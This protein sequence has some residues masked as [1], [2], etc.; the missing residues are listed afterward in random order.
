MELDQNHIIISKLRTSRSHYLVF[1][2][3]SREEKEYKNPTLN[4]SI[5]IDSEHDSKKSLYKVAKRK[6]KKSTNASSKKKN[7]IF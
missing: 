5:S 7:S 1:K 4:F 3:F 6:Q 2:D